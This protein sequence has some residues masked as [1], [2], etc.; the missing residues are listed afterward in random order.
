MWLTP[1]IVSENEGFLKVDHPELA[2]S[3][4][5][6]GEAPVQADG[7]VRDR[8]LYFRSRHTDWSFEIAD[9]EGRFPGDGGSPVKGFMREGKHPNASFMTIR[10]AFEIICCSLA[11]YLEAKDD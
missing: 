5:I 2:V 3:F 6:Y 11:E 9:D 10:E 7:E 4:Y 1:Y 8:E